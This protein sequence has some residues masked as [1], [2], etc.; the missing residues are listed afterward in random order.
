MPESILESVLEFVLESEYQALEL[1]DFHP[2]IA[3]NSS[4][5]SCFSGE[6]AV[7]L[8]IFVP[9][10]PWHSKLPRFDPAYLHQKHRISS[11]NAVFFK[12]LAQKLGTNTVP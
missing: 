12:V 2:I 9:H 1:L 3:Y 5:I 8:L 11:R 6:C 7:C 4:N 10:E